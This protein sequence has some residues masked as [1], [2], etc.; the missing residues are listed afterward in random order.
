M[1]RINSKKKKKSSKRIKKIII[2]MGI[3]GVVIAFIF[4]SNIINIKNI[5]ISIEEQKAE[6]S[7][8]NAQEIQSLSGLVIGDNLFGKTK[9]EI[10]NNI[11]VNPYVENVEVKRILNGTVN[12]KVTERKISYM[13]NYAGAY[14]Y[15][16]NQGYVLELNSEQKKV[17]ILLGTTTDFTSLA[18]GDSEEK[19][20]RLNDKDL[21]KLSMVNSIMECCT[22]NE[23][24]QL[25]S[26]I[27]IKDSKNYTLYLES[28]SKTVYLGDCK[29][30][31]TRILY[32][33]EII[34]NEKGKS[35]K[36]YANVDLNSRYFYF[37][38]GT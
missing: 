21:N 13:V 25:I 28:E 23:I 1:K 33:K 7:N 24:A 37:S 20:T 15:I 16:D 6:T 30:L 12:I 2:L 11:K 10:I 17:P 35:G 31:N 8:L 34:E 29:D 3:I 14:I 32:V 26:K 19:V 9:T 5:E 38:E 4:L 22:N 27:D 18:V 36:I